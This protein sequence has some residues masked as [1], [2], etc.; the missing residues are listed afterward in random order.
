MNTLEIILTLLAG[1]GLVT[2]WNSLKSCCGRPKVNN[3]PPPPESDDDDPPAE[4]PPRRPRRKNVDLDDTEVIIKGH[5]PF[6]VYHTTNCRALQLVDKEE[7]K[8]IKH[9][10]FCAE[11]MQI[12]KTKV[13]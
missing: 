13:D 6:K 10:P 5:P 8:P 2:I 11:R 12:S 7:R 3:P 1:L 9:C 4:C